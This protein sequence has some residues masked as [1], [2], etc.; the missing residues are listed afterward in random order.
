MLSFAT[1]VSALKTALGNWAV[2]KQPNMFVWKENHTENIFY[3]R[4][5]PSYAIIR[6]YPSYRA[7]VSNLVEQC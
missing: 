2:V 1:G 5:V 6:K 7:N 3:F 4:L